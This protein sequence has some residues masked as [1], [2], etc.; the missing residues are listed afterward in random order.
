[1]LKSL[2]LCTLSDDVH[3]ETRT[4]LFYNNRP[5]QSERTKSFVIQAQHNST[6]LRL[7]LCTSLHICHTKAAGGHA[8]RY[9]FVKRTW[10]ITARPTNPIRD[11][12]TWDLHPN[13]PQRSQ[14]PS[15]LN[16][17]ETQNNLLPRER[18]GKKRPGCA[19]Q[20]I[21]FARQ[22]FSLVSGHNLNIRISERLT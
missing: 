11:P 1:M 4:S 15:T 13:R 14:F 2:G 20:S 12:P 18:T 6:C 21:N 9:N 7:F 22:A 8:R 16:Q 17:V 5:P 3:S 19:M 10:P